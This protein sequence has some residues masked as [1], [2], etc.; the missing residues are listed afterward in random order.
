MTF[1][2][3]V[4]ATDKL[5]YVGIDKEHK[6]RK[7]AGNV[8]SHLGEYDFL[9]SQLSEECLELCST[10]VIIEG[11]QVELASCAVKYTDTKA[12]VFS[13]F[14][15][16]ANRETVTGLIVDKK[17]IVNQS[18]VGVDFV[19]FPVRLIRQKSPCPRNGHEPAYDLLLLLVITCLS[20]GLVCGNTHLCSK[21]CF[22]LIHPTD[23]IT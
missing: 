6:L 23:F 10:Y 16:F 5:P 22:G 11:T 2:R 8:M 13:T 14:L 20:S 12:P 17:F 15:I 18:P 7:T 9:G 19:E 4:V 21:G 1:S 3:R